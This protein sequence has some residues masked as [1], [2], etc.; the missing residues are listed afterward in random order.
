MNEEYCKEPNLMTITS[1]RFH[2]KFVVYN[3]YHYFIA[4][5]TLFLNLI[6]FFI[7]IIIKLKIN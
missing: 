7:T 2:L 1:K 3:Q 6:L 5:L 4:F